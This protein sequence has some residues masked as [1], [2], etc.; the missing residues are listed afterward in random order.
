[1]PDVEEVERPLA[2]DI[3]LICPFD[4]QLVRKSQDLESYG[5]LQATGHRTLTCCSNYTTVLMVATHSTRSS[6]PLKSVWE[7]QKPVLVRR[8]KTL[9]CSE[10]EALSAC[11]S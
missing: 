6:V 4:D 10:Q 5:K 7:V 2:A 11:Q 3:V 8:V 9:H 1:M